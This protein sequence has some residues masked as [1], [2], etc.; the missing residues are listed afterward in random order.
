LK[1]GLLTSASVCDS[2]EGSS[3]IRREIDER[4]EVAAGDCSVEEHANRQQGDCVTHVALKTA[5]RSKNQHL[6]SI[7][8]SLISALILRQNLSG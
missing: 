1:N 3:E 7:I 4:A 6:K 5:R 8:S 2:H